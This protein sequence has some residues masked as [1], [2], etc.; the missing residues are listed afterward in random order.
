MN[1]ELPPS[2][3]KV[4]TSQQLS[5][6]KLDPTWEERKTHHMVNSVVSKL[7]LVEMSEN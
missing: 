3:G 6:L 1:Y 7:S 4:A 5:I 2:R